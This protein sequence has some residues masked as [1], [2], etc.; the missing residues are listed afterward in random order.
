MPP[1]RRFAALLAVLTLASCSHTG[2]RG[3]SSSGTASNGRNPH[4]IP[5]VARLAESEEPN[6]LVR[7]FSNQESADDVTALLFEPFFRFD[8][9]ERPVPGLA[10]ELPTVH[11]GLISKDGLRITF[12]LR[13]NVYWSDG[14]PVTA[15]DVVFTW[16]A[17][18][19]GMNAV[20]SSAGFDKIKDIIV[21][22]PHRVT[23][24][25]K[26]PLGSAVYLFSEG[27]FP[28]L[29][30][31]ILSRYKDLNHIPYDAAPIGDGPFVLRRW[32][33][34]SEIDFDANPRYWRGRPRL[35]QVIIK[36]IPNPNTSVDQMRTKEIDLIDGVSKPLVGQLQGLPGIR[37][38]T[39]LTANY[40][41]M[42]F[43]LKNPILGDVHVRRAIAQA[44]DF[45][46]IVSDVYAGLGVRAATDIPPFSWAANRL[47]PIP[48][49]PAAARRSLDAAGWTVGSDGMRTK[50]GRRLSLSISTATDNRPNA[51][52]E[53]LVASDLKAVGVDITVKNFAGAVLF[54]PDGPLYGGTYDISWIVNTEAVDPDDLGTWG[55]DFWPHHG[56]NTDFYCN[57]RVDAFL[58]DAQ[59]HYDHDV[60]RKDYLEAW[61]IMLDEVPAVMVYWDDNVIALNTDFKNFKPSPV[62]TDYWNSWEWQ[63]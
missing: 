17:I 1:K 12:D 32:Q 55:C 51:N 36:I 6:S 10:M 58:R 20:V 15:E 38:Q 8:G 54:A 16:H 23:L 13:P 48:Y 63:I 44:V 56:A 46:K 30:A 52:A 11:N 4:T 18:A 43:N 24:I 2:G 40:R 50:G 53:E 21:D 39:Q 29:P 60:R 25:M 45:N 61:K 31:H 62:V 14:V 42:D 28:P 19:G 49:D 27:S 5:G 7:M 9:Q 41:H 59:L 26:E 57:H 35:R 33:H 22:S 3:A 37:I 47:S 34:G